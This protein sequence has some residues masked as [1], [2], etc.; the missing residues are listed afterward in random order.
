[1]P[2]RAGK[3]LPSRDPQNRRRVRNLQQCINASEAGVSPADNDDPSSSRKHRGQ[4]NYGI[5][6][7]YLALPWNA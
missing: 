1:M 2:S 3:H 6:I 7:P 5:K 4:S